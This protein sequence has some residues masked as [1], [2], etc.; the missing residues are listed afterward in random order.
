LASSPYD[1][2]DAPSGEV[3]SVKQI[4]GNLRIYQIENDEQGK[5]IATDWQDS[6]CS[7][8]D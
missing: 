2:P 7:W 3:G 6:Q 4:G 1:S 5:Y 8:K